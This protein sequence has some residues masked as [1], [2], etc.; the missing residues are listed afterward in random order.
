[1]HRRV[2]V[3]RVRIGVVLVGIG[4]ALLAAMTPPPA[5]ARTP[6]SN[7]PLYA[8]WVPSAFIGGSPPRKL[9]TS[10]LARDAGHSEPAIWFGPDGEMAVDGLAWL[11]FQVD[12]WKGTFGSTPSLF[13]HMDANLPQRGARL[14]LG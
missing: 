12:V 8:H 14:A 5:V 10:P 3:R 2:A 4:V 11:P 6:F 13:G 1:M 9:S 7:T